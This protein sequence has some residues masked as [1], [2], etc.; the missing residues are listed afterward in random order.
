MQG[1]A[2]ERE[3]GAVRE[4]GESGRSE[5]EARNRSA[6]GK[7]LGRLAYMAA[8]TWG[9][10]HPHALHWGLL[11]LGWRGVSVGAEVCLWPWGLSWA[12]DL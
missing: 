7:R 1:A 9:A 11:C 5:V 8:L 6:R 3:S 4:C 10:A 12:L 2:S